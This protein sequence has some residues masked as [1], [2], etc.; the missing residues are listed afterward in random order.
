MPRAPLGYGKEDHFVKKG[1]KLHGVIHVGMNDGEEIT[2]YW[3]VGRLPVLGFEPIKS[4]FQATQENYAPEIA[5]GK[6]VLVNM[7]L[8]NESRPMVMYVPFVGDIRESKGATGLRDIRS[9][10]STELEEV[11]CSRFDDWVGDNDWALA[12]YDTLVIDVQGMELQV[13]QG[14]GKYIYH[15]KYLMIECSETPWW[16]GEAS[17]YE[18]SDWLYKRGFTRD[19]NIVEHNDVMFIRT[20]LI[21]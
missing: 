20:D 15:M 14:F 19:S 2:W 11:W 9:L 21:K 18:I 8:G 6:V 7:A 12:Q 4:A 16:E 17:G 13:L 1:H 10:Y 3:H 5:S